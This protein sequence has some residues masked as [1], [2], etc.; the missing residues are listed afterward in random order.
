MAPKLAFSIRY[1]VLKAV[2]PPGKLFDFYHIQQ[3]E[4]VACPPVFSSAGS[5]PHPGFLQ[6]CFSKGLTASNI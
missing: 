1:M 6:I 5:L 2:Q 3:K 4:N